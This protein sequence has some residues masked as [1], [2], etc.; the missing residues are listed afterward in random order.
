MI[1]GIGCDIV[2]VDRFIK[3]QEQ[4]AKRILS[5]REYEIYDS[6]SKDRQVAFLAGRFAAKEAIYKACNELK[7]IGNIEVLQV[8]NKPVCNV[9]GYKIHITIS[10][11]KAYA[12]AY[13][14]CEEE[15]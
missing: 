5:E 2:A 12:I 6:F 7:M 14:I 15:V 9:H 8:D 4:L 1:V 3:N 10:H 13:A 11:E